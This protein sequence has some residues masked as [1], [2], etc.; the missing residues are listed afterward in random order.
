MSGILFTILMFIVA[1]SVLVAVHE[2]GHF[3]VAK[4]LGVKVLR[5]SIGMGKPIWTKRAGADQT[6]YV[7]AAL[8]LGGYV[9][10]LDEREGEV[11]EEELPR[12]FN[13]QPIW[14]RFAIV[15]AG[16]AFNFLFAIL[17]YWVLYVTGINGLRPFIGDVIP[18]SPA[19]I[20][21]IKAGGEIVE[22]NGE[23]T[24]SWEEVLMRIWPAI[25]DK[26]PLVLKVQESGTYTKDY[27]LDYS[28][29]V[30]ERSLQD[31]VKALGLLPFQKRIVPP[32][33]DKVEEGMP[34][35]KAGLQKNDRIL[36]LNDTVI[37][38]WADIAPFVQKHCS[39]SI[40][41]TYERNGEQKVVSLKSQIS[42]RDGMARALL[43]MSV[44]ES[45]P[46]VI[47]ESHQIKYT[48]SPWNAVS[49]SLNAIE[50]IISMN[51]SLI[52][53]IFTLEFSFRNVGGVIQ[54]AHA[55]GKSADMG[56]Q[57]FLVFLAWVS[58]SLG[59]MNLLPVPI[60]DGGHLMYYMI[61][62]VT[63]RPVSERVELIAQK[64]GMLLLMLLMLL[65]FYNDIMRMIIPGYGLDECP[66]F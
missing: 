18:Q 40:K 42:T 47:P 19:Q 56:Y 13:R 49:R 14:K 21:G 6:E 51:L 62:M 4:S 16:P 27:T 61:E 39:E 26:S 35:A 46:I 66:R 9:K 7:I 29:L 15:L 25:V 5:Y 34:A 65:A 50:N 1:I 22:V 57:R 30:L 63:R 55:A 23:H 41:L 59:I 43:G 37:S 52:K 53:K 32:I 10:M 36:K 64:I 12:A 38:D 2:F 20:A 44:Q 45:E 8:P 60:L 3:W 24:P 31:P 17:T 48:L 28:R 33:I 58:V 54:I 11:A